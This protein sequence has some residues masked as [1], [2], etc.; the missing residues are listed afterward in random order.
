MMRPAR[1]RFSRL[2]FLAIFCGAFLAFGSMTMAQPKSSEYRL[3][4]ALK[5]DAY[6][7]VEFPK[8]TS[9]KIRIPSLNEWLNYRTQNASQALPY[10][11]TVQIPFIATGNAWVA[12]S[13]EPGE[14]EQRLPAGNDLQERINASRSHSNAERLQHVQ[15]QIALPFK[16]YIEFPKRLSN[17]TTKGLSTY[18]GENPTQNTSSRADVADGPVSGAIHVIPNIIWGENARRNAV[19]PGIYRGNVQVTISASEE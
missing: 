1:L 11:E 16:V 4:V 17:R 10:L 3:G 8:G 14:I 12:I 18:S 9:F 15:P 5:V 13:V 2:L 19:L 7:H 6:A